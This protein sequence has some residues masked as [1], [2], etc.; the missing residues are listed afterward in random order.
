MANE[1]EKVKR[2]KTVSILDK[3]FW[4]VQPPPGLL[5]G[6]YYRAE[7]RFGRNF[8]ENPGH[9]GIMEVVRREGRIVFVEFNEVCSPAYYMRMQQNM[10]KR[11][12]D[13]GFFQASKERT[14]QT[15]VVLVN[16]LAHLEKQ[17][18]EENRLTGDFDLLTGASN[19]INKAML[20]LAKKVAEMMENPS[21]Q[22]YYGLSEPLE[23]GVTGYL[24]VVVQ[25]GRIIRCH[26]DEI[27]A[28]RPEEIGDEFLKPYYRQS[29]YHAPQ[30]ISTLGMG[31][32]IFSDFI[33][34]GVL[35]AQNLTDLSHMPRME[36]PKPEPER[37]N[38]LQLAEK[39]QAAMKANG[40]IPA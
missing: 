13:Y 35:Q 11:L 9:L 39:L 25:D 3:V 15:G 27:F 24:Q 8:E 32:N 14:A 22:A 6:E 12:S 20:P 21:G 38:Y 36:P 40:V 10:S 5:V 26:Y 28:D 34:K 2:E 16:G 37:E 33:E 18:I 4:S 23:P 1:R 19:S 17:M 31:F 30:Y 29:K 7:M